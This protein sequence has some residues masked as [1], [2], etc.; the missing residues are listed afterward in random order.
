MQQAE[1][2]CI[3]VR[4]LPAGMYI[5]NIQNGNNSQSMKFIKN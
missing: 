1:G 4:D 5:L 3:E 2:N